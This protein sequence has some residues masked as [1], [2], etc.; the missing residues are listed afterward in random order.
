MTNPKLKT[1]KRFNWLTFLKGAIK[2][3]P[4][5]KMH[6]KA[7]LMA[8]EWPTCACGQLCKRL[9]RTNIGS[10]QDDLLFT[11]GSVFSVD[12]ESR[13]WRGALKAFRAIEKRT[14]QLLAAQGPP[15]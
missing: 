5:G 2:K 4:S 7:M 10:P 9:P 14:A 8:R 13:K 6:T 1:R 15:Q 3:E 11:L 12:V